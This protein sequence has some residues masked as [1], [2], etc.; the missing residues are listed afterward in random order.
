M[1]RG[2][3]PQSAAN[4]VAHLATIALVTIGLTLI[5]ACRDV[6]VYPIRGAPTG[7]GGAGGSPVPVQDAATEEVPFVQDA[8]SE[9]ASTLAS[10]PPS[11]L[12]GYAAL[13]GGTTGGAAGLTVTVTTLDELM[14]AAAAPE[15]LTIRIDGLIEA[16]SQIDV[17]SDKTIEGVGAASGLTGNGL[18]VLKVHNVIIRN[19]VISKAVGVDA[20]Q[21]QSAVNVWIDHCDLSS[22][23]VQ[24]KTYYDGLVD[25]S[26]ACDNVTISWNHF[27]DHYHVTLVGHSADNGAEDTGKL[28]VTYYGNLFENTNSEMPRIRFGKAH[29]FNNHYRNVT[30]YAIVS[31]MGAAVL[32]ENNVFDDV[33]ATLLSH[34]EDPTDGTIHQRGNRLLGSTPPIP[35]NLADT[36]YVP[37]YSYATPDSLDLYPVD[38]VTYLVDTCAGIPAP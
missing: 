1:R 11:K 28:N 37:P 20:I 8:S 13:G 24:P 21:L 16:S 3:R 32:V 7:S 10:C 33:K 38:F 22:D 5:G 15:P 34:Y 36:P 35:T 30:T 19:L 27:H 12:I 26:H 9:E 25:I 4:A 14:L 17:A 18:R 23:M 6:Y 2:A 31:Q 29:V